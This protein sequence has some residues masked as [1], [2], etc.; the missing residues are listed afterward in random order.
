MPQTGTALYWFITYTTSFSSVQNRIRPQIVYQ[1]KWKHDH[2]EPLKKMKIQSHVRYS[3][4]PTSLHNFPRYKNVASYSLQ[5]FRFFHLL[6][7]SG[8][9]EITQLRNCSLMKCFAL[10]YNYSPLHPLLALTLSPNAPQY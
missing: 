2:K 3:K 7:W 10:I 9:M 1:P 4:K 6:H 8:S 5:E